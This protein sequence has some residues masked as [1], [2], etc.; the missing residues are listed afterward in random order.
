MNR[1][2]PSS[3]ICHVR[4]IGPRACMVLLIPQA[5]MSRLVATYPHMLMTLAPR[6]LSQQSQVLRRVDLA[7]EWIH[8]NAGEKLLAPGSTCDGMYIVLNGRCRGFRHLDSVTCREFERG[9]VIGQL[10]LLTGW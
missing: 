5:S 9:Q 3:G 6:I 2:G 4:N 1:Y 10:E 8:L 7:M